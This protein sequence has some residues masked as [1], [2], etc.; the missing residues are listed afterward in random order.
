MWS[1]KDLGL[2]RVQG[3]GTLGFLIGHSLQG[4]QLAFKNPYYH[5]S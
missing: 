2:K 3:N 5:V 4:S 1:D